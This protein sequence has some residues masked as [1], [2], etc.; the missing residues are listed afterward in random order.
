MK[1]RFMGLFDRMEP[2]SPRQKSAPAAL[3]T[4]KKETTLSRHFLH[5]MGT[6]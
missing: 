3:E 2:F 5:V 6:L 1:W 4:K